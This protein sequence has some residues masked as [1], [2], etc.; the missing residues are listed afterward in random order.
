MSGILTCVV[1][2]CMYGLTTRVQGEYVSAK[3]PTKFMTNSW[4]VQQQLR[5]RCDGS[6]EHGHLE[7]GRAAAA[8]EYPTKLSEAICRGVAEQVVYDRSARVCTHSLSLG[9]TQTWKKRLYNLIQRQPHWNDNLHELD[10]TP[11]SRQEQEGANGC[12]EL[13]DHVY[14]LHDFDMNLRAIDDVSGVELDPNMVLEARKKEM[15]YFRKLNVYSHVPRSELGKTQGKLI[16]TRWIDVNKADTTNPDY[17]SRLV[18]KELNNGQDPSLFASTPPP[19][20]SHESNYVDRR[21][22]RQDTKTHI[23]C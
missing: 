15:E 10:G 22:Q 17:R 7:G 19:I 21:D 11:R 18:G 9:A 16:K 23:D 6:H 4:C 20:G 5:V 13:C 3:K 14:A 1:D 12:K 8:A 2:Q